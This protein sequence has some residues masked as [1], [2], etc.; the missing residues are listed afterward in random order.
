VYDTHDFALLVVGLLAAAEFVAAASP[1]V[2]VASAITPVARSENA[3][4]AGLPMWPSMRVTRS[5]AATSAD[6]VILREFATT[7]KP[8]SKSAFTVL[9]PISC[10]APVTMAIFRGP[11]MVVS[12]TSRTVGCCHPIRSSAM[13]RYRS[14]SAKNRS[15]AILSS[16]TV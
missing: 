11:L 6:C 9:S 13:G 15:R 3:F 8:R 4:C 7:L 1:S 5:E 16:A 2:P 14:P 10:E 12:Q